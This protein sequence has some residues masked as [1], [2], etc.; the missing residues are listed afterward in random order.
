MCSFPTNACCLFRYIWLCNPMD[1]SLSGSSVHGILQARILEWVAMPS[2]RGSFW[3]RNWTSLCLLHWQAGFLPLAPHVKV[4]RSCPTL[5]DPM[6][7][8]VYGIFQARILEWIAIPFSRGSSQPRDRTQVSCTAGRFFTIWATE[9]PII[10]LWANN[11]RK[12]DHGRC[13]WLSIYFCSSLVS[14][15]KF[16]TKFSNFNE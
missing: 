12:R 14:T 6:D 4:T 8:T 1:C 5:Y 3:R 7:Y 13:S 11:Q 9:S 15:W 16:P 2:S 10:F